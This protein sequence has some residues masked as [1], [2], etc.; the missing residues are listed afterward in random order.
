MRSQPNKSS[1]QYYS[2]SLERGMS[3]LRLFTKDRGTWTLTQISKN[4]DLNKTSTFRFVNTLVQLGYLRKD[5]N[6][7]LIS[8]GA[9]SMTL[10]ASFY[11][12]DD[13][14]E[15]G[16]PLI[17]EAFETYQVNTEL[18][19]YNEDMIVVVYRREAKESF[20]P[21]F[22]ISRRK[23]QFYCSSLGKAVLSALPQKEM[24]KIV[25][26]LPNEKKTANTL[27]NK[28]DLIADLE[29]SKERGYALNNEEWVRGLIAIAAPL[30]NLHTNEV[31]GAVCFDFSTIQHSIK[32]VEKKYASVIIQLAGDISQLL[33]TIR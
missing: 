18:A 21:R 20:V 7:K 9:Q 6:T 1:K 22:P 31:K 12:T 25:K 19:L 11:R 3:I 24:M 2:T 10:G 14:Y 8:L 17:E 16:K 29:K 30:I 13:I 27:A 26:G 23:E 5:P 4:L 15:V 33:S 28:A 32:Q